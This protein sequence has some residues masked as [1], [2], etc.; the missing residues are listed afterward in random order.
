MKRLNILI[1]GTLVCALIFVCALV[2]WHASQPSFAD[3]KQNAK[4]VNWKH[5]TF[6]SERGKEEDVL[7]LEVWKS[8][9]GDPK[10]PQL[11]LLRLPPAISI[12]ALSMIGT[13]SIFW[14]L[15]LL[16]GSPA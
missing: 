1:P 2:G 8:A 15:G 12:M 6:K 16:V 3:E 11:A 10:W 5:V 9:A 13:V 4:P 7:V 14:A